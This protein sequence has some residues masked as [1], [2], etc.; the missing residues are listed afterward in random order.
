MPKP[1]SINYENIAAKLLADRGINLS[2]PAGL[3]FETR[4]YDLAGSYVGP[5]N[6]ELP[7][8][9]RPLGRK[10]VSSNPDFGRSLE[11]LRERLMQA[12]IQRQMDRMY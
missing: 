7:L 5:F 11:L 10:K 12:F 6:D 8:I 4:N 9:Q 2:T 3:P 1:K